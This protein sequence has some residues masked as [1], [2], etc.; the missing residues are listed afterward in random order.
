M[1]QFQ[2]KQVFGTPD[3]IAPEVILRKGYGMWSLSYFLFLGRAM[4]R[5]NYHVSMKTVCTR[6]YDIS[7]CAICSCFKELYSHY[8]LWETCQ[9]QLTQNCDSYF[10]NEGI[11]EISYKE[12][13]EV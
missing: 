10:R 9:T 2:D 11:G 5:V 1:Q 6:S 8:C 7:W 3:Y 12:I 13:V 4:V